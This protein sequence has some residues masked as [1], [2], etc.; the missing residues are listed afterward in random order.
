MTQPDDAMADTDGASVRL[1]AAIYR[2]MPAW[3]KVEL[4]VDANRTARRLAMAGLRLRH[5]GE[6]AQRLRR[7]LRGLELGEALATEAY[8]ALDDVR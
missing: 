4:V 6:S 3:R 5:P 8:G 2:D 1:L 7:R